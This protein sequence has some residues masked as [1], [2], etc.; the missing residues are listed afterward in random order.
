MIG[1]DL[2][3]NYN[4]KEK[5][6]VSLAAGINYTATQYTLQQRRDAYYT[7]TYSMDANY[8]FGK[9]FILSSV[10]DFL[11]YTGRSDGFNQSYAIWNAAF[12]KQLFKNNRGELRASVFD[13]LNKNR[14][15]VRNV[16]ETYIEDVQ[17]NAL[18]RFFMLSFTYKFNQMGRRDRKQPPEHAEPPLPGSK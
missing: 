11:A 14:N 5:L 13:L 8:E 12:A 1:E 10:V 16:S 18:K 9:G 15:V 2:R 6:D 4:Y 17:A 3:L 7:H